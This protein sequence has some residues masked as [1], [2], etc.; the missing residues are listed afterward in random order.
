MV[1]RYQMV[2]REVHTIVLTRIYTCP[3]VLCLIIELEC[4]DNQQQVSL[5]HPGISESIDQH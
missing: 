1:E 2:G 4:L 3:S 5:S